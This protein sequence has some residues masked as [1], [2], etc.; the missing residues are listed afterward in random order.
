M[1]KRNF[2]EV[3]KSRSYIPETPL[4]GHMYFVHRGTNFS[5]EDYV[6]HQFSENQRFQTGSINPWPDLQATGWIWIGLKL[7]PDPMDSCSTR[8]SD[9]THRSYLTCGSISTHGS[10]STCEFDLADV[11]A[12]HRPDRT[13]RSD[14]D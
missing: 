8:G 9:S 1:P 7:D 2:K 11:D 12:V 3:K 4:N 6:Y 5:T 13:T 10:F 14:M